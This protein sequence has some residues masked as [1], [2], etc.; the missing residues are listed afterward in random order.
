MKV[1]HLFGESLDAFMV[2]GRGG[3][4]WLGFSMLC[5]LPQPPVPMPIR[6]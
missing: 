6:R 1:L 2:A 4:A 5:G 3:L